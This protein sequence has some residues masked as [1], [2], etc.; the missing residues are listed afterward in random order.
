LDS[1][2]VVASLEVLVSGSLEGLSILGA[3]WRGRRSLV[4]WWSRGAVTVLDWLVGSAVA[5][6]LLLFLIHP[7]GESREASALLWRKVERVSV[8]VE[9]LVLLLG[10]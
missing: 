9:W 7:G 3:W 5:I 6:G 2:G 10:R 1:L 8:E 4:R